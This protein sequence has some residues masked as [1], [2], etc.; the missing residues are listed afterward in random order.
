MGVRGVVIGPRNCAPLSPLTAAASSGSLDAIDVR[1]CD[2]ELS[3]LFARLRGGD[4]DEE[5]RW[6]IIGLDVKSESDRDGNGDREFVELSQLRVSADERVM[7]VVGNEARGL[8]DAVRDE[9][10]ALVNVTGSQRALENGVDSLN[11]ASACSVALFHITQ[12][13]ASLS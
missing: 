5:N 9:C 8:S 10:D 11:V 7:V 6:R 12:N 13:T 2:G 1:R 4:G 3:A